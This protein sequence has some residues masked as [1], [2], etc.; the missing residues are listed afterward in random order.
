MQASAG[1]RDNNDGDGAGAVALAG[2]DGGGRGCEY[3][4]FKLCLAC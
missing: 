1:D 3:G 4:G 2:C